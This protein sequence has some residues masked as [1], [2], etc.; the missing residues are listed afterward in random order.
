MGADEAYRLG[1]VQCV[2]PPGQQ[3]D[4]AIEITHKIAAAAPLGI[5]ATLGSAHRA[6]IDGQEAAFAAL[7]TEWRR[8]AQ[9]ED[10]QEYFR[11]LQEKRA[12]W[13][14]MAVEHAPRRSLP[15]DF[16]SDRHPAL[17][18]TEWFGPRNSS[19]NPNRKRPSNYGSPVF[20]GQEGSGEAFPVVAAS[21]RRGEVA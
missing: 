2:T 4:R 11:A 12:P 13:Q 9:S 7:F 20:N 18:R 15:P 19:A 17:S 21:A 10:R 8:L 16:S 5:R 6:L 1:L 14:L 3:L